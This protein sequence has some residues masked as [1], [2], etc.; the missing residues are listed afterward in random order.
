[1]MPTVGSMSSR[2]SAAA[3]L[4]AV[5]RMPEPENDRAVAAAA[6]PALAAY[7]S[8]APDG[9]EQLFAAFG[10]LVR[11]AIARFLALRLRAHPELADDLTHEVFLA[12]FR[13]D[14]RKLRTFAGRGGCSFG[15]WLK[16]VSVRLAID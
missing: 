14:G 11:D 4:T 3:I 12:L 5:H 1:M 7:L 6:E 8:G 10:D 16:V 15:G 13:D 9:A 2:R